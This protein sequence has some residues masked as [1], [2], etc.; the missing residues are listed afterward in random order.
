MK[1]TLF[2]ALGLALT[3]LVAHGADGE[4]KPAA[5]PSRE[6]IMKKYDKNGDGKL[7]QDER[8]ALMKDRQAESLKKY[9]KN[10]DGKLDESELQA[11]RE[12]ARKQREAAQARRQAEQKQKDE[13]K[14]DKK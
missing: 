6:E 10:G 1:K 9:D 13:K 2:I 4:A 11:R 5:P 8:A 12:D 14:D 3:G 7:D